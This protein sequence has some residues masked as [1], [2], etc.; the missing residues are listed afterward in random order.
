MEVNMKKSGTIFISILILFFFFCEE[1]IYQEVDPRLTNDALH[2]KI[3]GKVIQKQSQAKV[4]ICQVF[5]I[6]STIIDPN[7]GSFMFENMPIG[8]YD[9]FIEAEDFRTYKRH[10]IMVEGAGTTYIGEIDLSTIPDLVSSHYPENHQEILYNNRSSRLTVSIL[11]TQPM[12]R[13]SVENA[14]STEPPTE[15]IFYWG[16]YTTEP[17]YIYFETRSAGMD[18]S[19]T[20]T[21]YSK[22]TSLVYKIAS[23][24]SYVDTT[25]HVRLAT[26]AHDTTGNYLR[27]PLE[28][29]FSTV[30]SSISINGIQTDPAHG[31]VDVDLVYY[32]GIKLIFP[33]NMDQ[34]STESAVTLIPDMT[35]YFLWPERNSLTI[36]TG[37]AFLADTT[38]YIEVDS[39]AKDL[40]GVPM[41]NIFSFS[42][43]T[44]PIRLISTYPRNGQL[45][46]DY[47]EPLIRLNF[48]TFMVK[49]TVVEA[50]H[51][52]PYVSGTFSWGNPSSS[53][54]TEIDFDPSVSLKPNTKYTI[55]IDSTA[56]DLFGSMMK[57]SYQ[58]SFVTRPE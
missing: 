30:Q 16:M 56:E 52:D 57:E 17:S 51:I 3:V 36:Y 46:V 5:P 2:G 21:T 24:D 34:S 42:F 22:I 44:A 50:F 10:N 40:D 29:S 23:K 19:A 47:Q 1:N 58:F 31:D 49:S 27:F 41:G 28:F 9:L 4:K 53:H 15:G 37:G 39:T 48:N 38:Y 26:S 25:Y 55:T 8:N 6:D 11:F 7:N 45:F 14:F 12:D 54:N 20:I 32:E 13:E 43:T 18:P 35:K 33:R